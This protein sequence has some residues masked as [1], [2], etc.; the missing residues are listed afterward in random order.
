MYGKQVTFDLVESLAQSGYTIIAGLAIGI[1]ATVHQAALNVGGK[2]ISI[3][4]SGLQKIYPVSNHLLAKNIV[5]NG[6]TIVSEFPLDT[7]AFKSNFPQR[8]RIISGLSLGTMI[9][10]AAKKSGALITARFAI[11]QNREVFA[12]PG[13][14]LEVGRHGSHN[15]I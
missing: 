6:G 11:D 3:L 5:K 7:P 12:V 2:T 15:F 14:I 1:D 13:S 9:T 10:Q 4:G 8:N